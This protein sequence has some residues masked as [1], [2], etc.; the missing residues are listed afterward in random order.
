MITAELAGNSEDIDRA[1]LSNFV[2][3]GKCSL[4]Q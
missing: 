4:K 3:H 1:K 2:R